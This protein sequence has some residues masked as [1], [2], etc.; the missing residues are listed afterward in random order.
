MLQ[1]AATGLKEEEEKEKECNSHFTK[2]SN[3]SF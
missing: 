1:V 2:S 3:H